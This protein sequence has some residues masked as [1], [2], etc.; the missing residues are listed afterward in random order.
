MNG[1][2]AEDMA[3]NLINMVKSDSSDE[4]L[5][6]LAVFPCEVESVAMLNETHE[7]SDN[8]KALPDSDSSL[9][10]FDFQQPLA[11]VWDDPSD[12]QNSDILG[13]QYQMVVT[14]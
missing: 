4:A 7:N 14:G 12:G 13:L 6:A 5:H 9:P 10:K 2:S 3:T 1:V 11:V 8:E